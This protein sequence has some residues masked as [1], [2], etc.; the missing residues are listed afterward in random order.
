MS[1]DLGLQ[2]FRDFKVG[3]PNKITTV[4]DHKLLCS[5]HNGNQQVSICTEIKLQHQDICYPV[6]YQRWSSNQADYLS[7]HAKPIHMLDALEQSEL[8]DLNNLLYTLHVPPL[9]WITLV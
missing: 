3:S 1:I 8:E 6:K 4:T 9:S 2:R 5:V 7:R